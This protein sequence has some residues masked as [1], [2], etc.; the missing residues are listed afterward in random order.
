M[1][2]QDI[3]LTVRILDFHDIYFICKACQGPNYGYG[4]NQSCECVNG[5]CLAN[6]IYANQSCTCNA[7]Y[8]TPF[9]DKLIDICGETIFFINKFLNYEK[10]LLFISGTQNPCNVA[11]E[12][13]AAGFS[14][15][16]ASCTCKSGYQRNSTSS[17][18]TG[19]KN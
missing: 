18:C 13:C 12:D 5:N 1:S 17:N 15:I 2:Q 6:A 19:I 14:S 8:A 16:N 4:C 9:C 10:N 3:Y 7:G 11:T